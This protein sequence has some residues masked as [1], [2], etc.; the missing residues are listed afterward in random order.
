MCK[1]EKVIEKTVGNLVCATR[2]VCA[3]PDGHLGKHGESGFVWVD[4]KAS[5]CCKSCGEAVKE[6]DWP[7][8]RSK[9]NPEGH[10]RGAYT[11]KMHMSMKT[12][13]WTRRPR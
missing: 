12:Q 5:D 6:G 8:C 7:Y 1:A 11:F 10:T 4:E 2:L 9:A 13:G 3:K